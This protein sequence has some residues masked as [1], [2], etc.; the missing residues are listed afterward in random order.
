[1]AKF[2]YVKWVTEYK[3]SLNEQ[4]INTHY[5]GNCCEWCDDLAA[6]RAIGNYPPEGCFDFD[7]N[8]CPRYRPGVIEQEEPTTEPTDDLSKDAEKLAS[9]PLLDRINTK[10]EWM[11]IMDALMK[12]ANS[13]DQV[14]D[15]IKRQWLQGAMKNIGK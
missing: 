3:K 11:D 6:G 4:R 13:I 14:N 12:H 5:K 9:H 1:M 2:D 7:C 15:S 10:D 8:D